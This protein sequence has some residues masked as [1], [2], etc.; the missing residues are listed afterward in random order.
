MKKIDVVG[1]T[2]DIGVELLRI[3]GAH[4]DA[5][6]AVIT[7]RKEAD[8]PVADMFPSLRRR[9]NLN[10]S[11][12][13]AGGLEKCDIV[14]FATSNGVAMAETLALLKAGV[15]VIDLAADFR[16]KDITSRN[17]KSGTA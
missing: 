1:G 14:F 9:V 4:P 15:R 2:G 8:T 7:S 10:F 16:V 11:D 13:V 17:G 3:L 5:Q 6:L 12:P